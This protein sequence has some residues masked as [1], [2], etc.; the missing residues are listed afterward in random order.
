[1]KCNL[2]LRVCSSVQNW[3]NRCPFCTISFNDCLYRTQLT[4]DLHVLIFASG[5]VIT[6]MFSRLYLPVQ[7]DYSGICCS[8]VIK[9][10]IFLRQVGWDTGEFIQAAIILQY[11]C[12][13]NP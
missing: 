5:D 7:R 6:Q 11:T 1:M 8:N 4:I 3:T 9:L 12:R 10:E 2:I 13:E